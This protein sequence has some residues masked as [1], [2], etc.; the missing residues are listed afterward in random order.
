MRALLLAF[1]VFLGAGRLWAVEPG[2]PL[3]TAGLLAGPIELDGRLDEPAWADAG[4]IP[5]LT[6]QNPTPG[7]PTP[8]TTR[9]LVLAD[10]RTLYLGVICTDPAP[11]RIAVHTLQRDG[12]LSADDTLSLVL[13]TFGDGRTGYLFRVNAAGAR[14][15]GLVS[16]ASDPSYDWDGIWDARTRRTETGWTA[17]IAISARTLR[18]RSGLARWGF[19]VERYV[20]RERLTTRW[21]GATLDASFVDLSRAGRLGGVAALRQGL[22]ISAAPF[23]VGRYDRQ[24]EPSPRAG[25][26]GSTGSTGDLGID[27]GYNLTPAL[28]GELTVHT[29]FAETEVDTRQIN[30]T[31]FP[32]FFP[33]KRPFFLEGSNLFDFATGLGSDFLPFYSRRVGLVAGQKVPIDDGLKLLGEAG[34]WS[35]AALDV[36]TGSSAA[37]PAVNLFAGRATYDLD[38][39]LRL[40]TLLTHGDPRG[41]GDNTFAS[42]DAVWKTSTFRGDKNLLLS[43]WGAR[44][45]GDATADPDLAAPSADRGRAG[46]GARAEYPN[47]LFDSYLQVNQYGGALDPALG[48]LPR[49]GTRQYALGN[50]YQ[51]RPAE[52]GPFGWAR[53][54]FFETYFTRVDDLAGRPESWRLFTAPFNVSTRSGEHFEIDWA[55]ELERLDQPFEV[56]SGVFIPPGRYRFD[57]YEVEAQSSAARPLRVGAKVW[58]GGFYGGRLAQWSSFVYWTGLGGHLRVELDGESDFGRLPQGDFAQRLWQLKT[59]YAFTPDLTV[60]AFTQ[61][62]SESRGLGL[63]SRLRWTIAPGRDLFLVWNRN[64]EQSLGEGLRFRPAADQLTLKLRWT[65]SW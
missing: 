62:D 22:G 26:A 41:L 37:A 44:S 7:K 36:E 34:P 25:N 16:G 54:F 31:R 19:N 64:W 59:F 14:Q 11:D 48:F 52:Q 9:V 15:D 6:Q 12:D 63:N 13:D 60:S 46:W 61:Y 24:R 43:A 40:G 30:L 5:A 1:V 42:F 47:D 56:V 35:L 29:D 3:V 21:A 10:A 55:P 23:G 57:R 4:V 20:A 38:S 27:L 45:A 49:P 28:G 8:F 65:E 17:E 39:H 2:A 18:F 50:A 58:F 53:Q 33:E 32:L 51:P